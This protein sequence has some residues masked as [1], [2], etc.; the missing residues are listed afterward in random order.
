MLTIDRG[1][2]MVDGVPAETSE[3]RSVDILTPQHV[4]DVLPAIF[5]STRVVVDGH[6]SICH[7]RAHP[8]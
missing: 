6:I 4:R 2:A 3:G 7:A 5:K 1:S 8:K